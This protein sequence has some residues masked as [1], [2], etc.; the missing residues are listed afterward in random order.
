MLAFRSR[1]IEGRSQTKHVAKNPSCFWNQI[2]VLFL[3]DSLAKVDPLSGPGLAVSQYQTNIEAA[4]AYLARVL[5]KG[6]GEDV[7]IMGGR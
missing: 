1:R 4:R 7:H 6:P 2:G 5:A 3:G